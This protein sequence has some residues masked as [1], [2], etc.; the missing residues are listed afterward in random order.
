MD[1]SG[2]VNPGRSAVVVLDWFEE[3]QQR[4]PAAK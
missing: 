2:S 3:L 1:R 4:L